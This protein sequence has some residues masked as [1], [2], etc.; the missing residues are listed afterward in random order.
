MKCLKDD[1]NTTIKD[2]HLIS[3]A[4]YWRGKGYADIKI[5]EEIAPYLF[6][7]KREFTQYKLSQVTMLSSM[8]AIRIYEMLKKQELLGNRTFFIDELRKKLAIKEHQYARINAFKQKVLEIAK[9]EINE[10]T[11]ILV[12]F[13]LIKSG[14]KITAVQFDITPKN[15]KKA[16]TQLNFSETHNCATN[17]K[18]VG[19]VMAYGFNGKTAD[20]LLSGLQSHEIENAIA[21]VK[22][23]IAKGKVKNPKAMLRTALKEKWNTDKID[24][25]KPRKSKKASEEPQKIIRNRSTFM[26]IFDSIFKR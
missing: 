21:A 1:G 20:R 11:D 5:S 24:C 15:H 7:L 3:Y 9:R 8:Y 23:Q 10:K 19:E 25:E 22:N 2:L 13:K 16:E 18:Y 26:K 4:E 17:G 14:R 6:N 12:D